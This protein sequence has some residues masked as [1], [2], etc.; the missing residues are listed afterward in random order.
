MDS[1][2]PNINEKVMKD[3]INWARQFIDISLEE[4]NIILEAKNLLLFKDG[5]PWSKKGDSF[6]DVGQGLYDGAESC[7]LVGLFLLSE[8]SKID[9]PHPDKLKLSRKKL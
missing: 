6:F 7:E 1:F 8:L 4:E 5:T 2:Y 3:S 9:R